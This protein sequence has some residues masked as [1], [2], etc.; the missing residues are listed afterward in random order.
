VERRF[1]LSRLEWAQRVM[2]SVWS[3]LLAKFHEGM[4]D[5]EAR[6]VGDGMDLIREVQLAL[7]DE[8]DSRNAAR[9]IV[10]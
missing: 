10:A 1:G 5:D 9:R 4:S 6:D 3:R 7:L 8:E 2:A